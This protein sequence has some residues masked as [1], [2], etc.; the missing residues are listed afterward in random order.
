MTLIGYSMAVNQIDS[1]LLRLP[2]ELR[3]KI[4]TFAVGGFVII[5]KNNGEPASPFEP[6]PPTKLTY[7]LA[8]AT[9]PKQSENNKSNHN[10]GN[11]DASN[12]TEANIDAAEGTNANDEFENLFARDDDEASVADLP[13]SEAEQVS[14]IFTLARVC[15]QVYNET[16]LLQ[17]KKNVFLFNTELA[18]RSFSAVLKDEQR[19]AINTISIDFEYVMDKLMMFGGGGMPSLFG[20]EAPT[21]AFR[22]MLPGLKTIYISPEH[23]IMMA[24]ETRKEKFAR[25]VA[26]LDLGGECDIGLGFGCFDVLDASADLKGSWGI[27]FS[28]PVDGGDDPA[29]IDQDEEDTQEDVEGTDAE[30]DMND[31]DIIDEAYEEA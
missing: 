12:V 13:V 1:P 8:I 11:N 22:E 10:N 27:R 25:M 15:R 3:N 9:V 19:N 7:R 20:F 29:D 30:E 17:Y 2:G 18:L 21:P 23:L 16:T 31:L 24:G 26:S 6:N 4:Y 14:G 5:V 28:P